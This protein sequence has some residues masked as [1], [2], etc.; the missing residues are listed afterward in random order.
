MRMLLIEDDHQV[1]AHIARGLHDAGHTVEVL[2]DGREA[3]FRTAA[4]RYDA[5]ILD[6]ML[7]H[8]DGLT[9]LR[10]IRKANDTTPVLVLSALGEVDERIRGLKAGGDDYLP[11]PF[12]LAE[13]L[14][15]IE[16][17][18]R[19][20]APQNNQDLMS[21]ADLEL[22]P[23]SQKVTRAGREI[24]LTE[25]Q[26]RILKYFLDHSCQVVTRSML[27]EALW[28]YQVDPQPNIIDQHMSRLRQKISGPGEPAL[29]RTV[30]GVGYVLRDPA[31]V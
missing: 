28:N 15:R 21:F 18:A 29:I 4:E 2:A 19:R 17:M 9:I 1:S 25:R 20:P 10:T 5:I 31:R 26:F 3:L 30:R 11:K 7:P 8:V 27:L 6:R 13:L 23:V 24:D 12:V 22:D 16:V 14:A